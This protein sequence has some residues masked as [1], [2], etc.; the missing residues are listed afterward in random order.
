MLPHQ[1]A[2][3]ARHCLEYIHTR[4]AVTRFPKGTIINAEKANDSRGRVRVPFTHIVPTALD[5]KAPARARPPARAPAPSAPHLPLTHCLA[6]LHT[7]SP[8]ADQS[9]VPP[10]RSHPPPSVYIDW[11]E[12][13]AALAGRSAPRD[14]LPKP[15]IT[16]VLTVVGAGAAIL[17]ASSR[18]PVLGLFTPRVLQVAGWLAAAGYLLDNRGAPAA[19]AGSNL[20]VEVVRPAAERPALRARRGFQQQCVNAWPQAA[21]RRKPWRQGDGAQTFAYRALRLHTSFSRGPA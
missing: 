11:E 13:A 18:A 9:R 4:A 10:F 12:A 7:A 3:P 17:E 19:A 2:H 16:S 5:G 20:L 1:G 14:G 8:R 15:P 6:A 21:C